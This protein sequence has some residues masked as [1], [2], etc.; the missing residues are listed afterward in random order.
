M[1][2]VPISSKNSRVRIN[3]VTVACKQ[4]TVNV[5]AD[6]L[7]TTNFE[8][9]GFHENITGIR[10]LS[11]S[12][13]LD[14]NASIN[15]HEAGGGTVLAGSIINSILLYVNA[16]AA[17]AAGPRWDISYA[18]IKSVSPRADV[19]STY[20][21]TIQGNATGSFGYPSGAADATT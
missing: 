13:E 3:G 2:H 16:P 10:K 21:V 17:V 1:A 20:G 6:E 9:G 19:K 7:E 5:E 18:F 14:Y 12:I 8:S 11:F 4:W 15:L